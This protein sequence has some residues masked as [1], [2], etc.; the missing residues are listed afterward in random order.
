M[1]IYPCAVCEFVR[2]TAT[3]AATEDLQKQRT[4]MEE[5]RW[6]MEV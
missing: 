2:N 3:V 5:R 1:I 4:R 6:V